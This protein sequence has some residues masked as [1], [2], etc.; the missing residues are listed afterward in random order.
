MLFLEYPKCSTCRKAKKWLDAH[1]FEYEDRHII[2]DNPSAQEIRDWQVQGYLQIINFFNTNGKLFRE[3]GLSTKLRTMSNFEML[4]LL[5]S[6]GMLV[7]RPILVDGDTVLVGFRE[8][9]WE[10]ALLNR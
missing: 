1:G 2:E 5:G 3:M 4:K 10:K 6:D 9:E 7:K 8:A